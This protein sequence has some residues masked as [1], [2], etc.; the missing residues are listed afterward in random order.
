MSTVKDTCQSIAQNN[1]HTA[2]SVPMSL[3][4]RRGERALMSHLHNSRDAESWRRFFSAMKV[5]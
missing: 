1:C 3:K 5:E 2:L 4:S